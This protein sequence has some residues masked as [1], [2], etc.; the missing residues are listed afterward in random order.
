WNSPFG[1]ESSLSAERT[2]IA[3]S[4]VASSKP[5]QAAQQMGRAITP[6]TEHDDPILKRLTGM[7]YPRNDALKALEMYDYDIN[8]VRTRTAGGHSPEHC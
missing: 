6:G 3:N 2:P 1:A 4:P 7:G 8:M 5:T